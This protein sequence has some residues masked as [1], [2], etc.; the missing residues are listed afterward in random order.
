MIKHLFSG[1]DSPKSELTQKIDNDISATEQ[2][3]QE[4]QKQLEKLEEQKEI[5]LAEIQQPPNQSTPLAAQIQKLESWLASRSG[6][7]S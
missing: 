2:K 6:Q 4:A 5:A 1:S 7:N 3:L